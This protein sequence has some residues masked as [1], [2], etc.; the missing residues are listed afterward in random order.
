MPENSCEVTARQIRIHVLEMV[1][2]ARCSHIGSAL[3]IAEIVAVLYDRILRLDPSNPDWDLRDRFILSKGHGCATVYAVLAMKGFFPMEWLDSYYLDG[4]RLYGHITHYGIPGV[5]ASTGSLGHGLPIA[6]GMALSG[7]SDNASYRVFALLSD[8]ECDEGPVWEAMLFGSHHRLD[9]LT[10]I[11]DYNKIQAC[12]R[13]EEVLDLEPLAEKVSAFGWAVKEVDGHDCEEIESVL[14]AVPFED[15][16]PSCVIA[17]TVKGKGVSFMEND[18]LWH[19]KAPDDDE[20]RRAL[21]EL[22]DRE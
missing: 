12:G 6:S 13:T 16:K 17:H 19:Y 2:R 8:G 14:S 11:I 15:G 22:A 7:K 3:S 20:L 21:E 4:G 10:A 1:H 5:E 9:N 18:V